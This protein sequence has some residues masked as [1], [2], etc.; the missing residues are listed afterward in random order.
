MFCKCSNELKT[1]IRKQ[2][3]KLKEKAFQ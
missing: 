1:K 3:I 2:F